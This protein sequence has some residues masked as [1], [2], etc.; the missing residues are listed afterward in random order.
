MP[1]STARPYG[2]VGASDPAFLASGTTIAAHL[3]SATIAQLGALTAAEAALEGQFWLSDSAVPQAV[4]YDAAAESGLVT[5]SDSPAT[6][7][8]VPIV[9]V[10]PLPAGPEDANKVYS[11]NVSGD[12][13]LVTNRAS[14]VT[15]ITSS[16]NGALSAADSNVQNAL[17]T[18]DD[19]AAVSVNTF[20]LGAWAGPSGGLYTLTLPAATHGKG[21]N[22]MW[23]I[24]NT[25]ADPDQYES[26]AATINGFGDITWSVAETP[27]GRFAGRVLVR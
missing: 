5:P 13:V 12:I 26:P 20:G 8:W 2:R 7:R 14:T 1:K 16:F 11:V 18:L 22:P 27:D 24:I 19:A 6:G 17:N 23:Q 3:P 25:D 9:P 10:P 4:A 15:T 21:I